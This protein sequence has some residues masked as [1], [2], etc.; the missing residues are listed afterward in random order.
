M[1]PFEF[2]TAPPEDARKVLRLTLATPRQ[3]EA[4]LERHVT[5][6]LQYAHAL[7]LDLGRQW[8][9][10]EGRETLTAC[11]C[12]ESPG[13]TAILL[14]PDGGAAAP[15]A[16]ALAALVQH[17]IRSEA[18]RDVHVL[19]CLI[20]PDHQE[21]AAL[22]GRLGFTDLAI[23]SYMEWTPPVGAEPAEPA[24]P[25]SLN[26][27]D[28]RWVTYD[29]KR[30]DEFS[31]LVAATYRD[32]LDCPGLSKLRDI[33]DVITGHKASG[34]FHPDHWLLLRCRGAAIGCILFGEHPLKPT[35]DL[36][37]MGVCPQWRRKGIARLLLGR[38][39]ALATR[40]SCSSVTL[41]VDTNNLPALEL[42]RSARFRET[43]RRRAMIRPLTSTFV[44][45]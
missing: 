23:L 8:V 3:S 24:L 2:K 18:Q 40:R 31:R 13:R 35:M 25:P 42:Y 6:F 17:V 38:G 28:I 32:S 4:N 19:Q 10:T 20:R 15:R 11:T 41:A 12:I 37:Y 44:E 7:S 5:A 33:D 21:H 26:S 14:L 36:V 16:D 39:L 9:C 29:E 30:H 45:T 34:R 43:T 22:L 1:P 27:D